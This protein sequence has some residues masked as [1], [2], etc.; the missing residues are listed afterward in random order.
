[1]ESN[2]NSNQSF[3]HSVGCSN[4]GNALDPLSH[5]DDLGLCSTCKGD[6]TRIENHL[7]FLGITCI[8]TLLRKAAIEEK[9]LTECCKTIIYYF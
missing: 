1:M 7:A 6:N 3:G 2:E 8:E 4:C 9:D 5:E